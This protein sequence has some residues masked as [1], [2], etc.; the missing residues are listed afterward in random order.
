MEVKQPLMIHVDMAYLPYFDLPEDYHFGQH[1]VVVA[2]MDP[3]QGIML[4]ADRDGVL[5]P[6]ST[7]QLSKARA[8][9]FKP[10]PPM[11]TWYTFDFSGMR[12]PTSEDIW[13]AIADVC[14]TMLRGPISNLGVRGIMRAARA[15][16][17]WPR[18][19]NEDQLRETAFNGYIFI[20][21][22]GGTGGG[23]FRYMYSRFLLEAATICDCPDLIDVG[24]DLQQVGDGWQA[25]AL[26]FK[27]AAAEEDPGG[28]LESLR[29]PLS[30]MAER[31][32]EIW[33]SLDELY[34]AHGA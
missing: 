32:A 22:E 25:I 1:A 2:G 18:A 17:D 10:F 12:L 3:V 6:I 7:E 11:N 5:H 20:D 9:T 21:A 29:A 31:E 8:S 27:E 30:V 19:L 23:M 4:L 13:S 28:F 34:T 16:K 24:K 26:G 33:E 14:A 15:I